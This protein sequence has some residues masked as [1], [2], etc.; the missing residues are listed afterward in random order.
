MEG[1]VQTLDPRRVR[2]LPT[3]TVIHMLYEGLM[4]IGPDGNPA[5]ALA[6]IVSISPDQL[7]Y[8]FTLRRSAWSDGQ[9]VT[10]SDFAETWKS[11]LDPT[12]PSPNAYQLY[13]IRG[14]KAAK[15]GNASLNAIGVRAI[16]DSTLESNPRTADALLS[17]LF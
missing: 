14:A 9:P 17:F 6:E 1:D 5:P 2:Y 12:F 3:A 15:E 8:T 16:D 11:V 7:T 13:P 4:R 10:A